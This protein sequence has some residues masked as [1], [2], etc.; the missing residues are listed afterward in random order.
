MRSVSTF[1][2]VGTVDA[3]TGEPSEA[4]AVERP[5]SVSTVCVSV[6]IIQLVYALVNIRAG[7][8]ISAETLITV[9]CII[10]NRIITACL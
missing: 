2:D 9:A 10:S 1:V 8:A 6:A 4:S 5:L 7:E 3:I